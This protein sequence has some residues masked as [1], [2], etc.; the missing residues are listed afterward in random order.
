MSTIEKIW[1]IERDIEAYK[2]AIEDAFGAMEE[3]EREL[4]EQLQQYPDAEGIS[5]IPPL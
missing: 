5:D 3:A 2:Q 4:A 1:Q